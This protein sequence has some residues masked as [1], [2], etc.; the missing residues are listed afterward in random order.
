MLIADR[1]S[2]P[3]GDA[4]TRSAACFANRHGCQPRCV[5]LWSNLNRSVNFSADRST[6]RE[7]LV[8]PHSKAVMPVESYDISFTRNE[9]AADEMKLWCASMR[10][11]PCLTVD[12][13]RRMLLSPSATPSPPTETMEIVDIWCEIPHRCSGSW[14]R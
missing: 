9:E 5:G 14:A 12:Q 7:S 13:S 6:H 8:Y 4:T 10:F 3:C 1:P 2:G 11:F